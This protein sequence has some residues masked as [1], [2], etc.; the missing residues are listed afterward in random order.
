MVEGPRKQPDIPHYILD[1]SIVAK[2][3]LDDERHVDQ[4][5]AL[6]RDVG[7]GRARV[8]APDHMRYEAANALRNAHRAGRITREDADAAV[9]DL[10]VS[11]FPFVSATETLVGAFALCLRLNTSLYD[12][13][14]LSLADLVGGFLVSDDQ[15]LRRALGNRPAAVMWL[16]DYEAQS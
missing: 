14:Y 12:A 7:L 3:Y 16:E 4:A 15:R 1:A 13:L 9:L 6:R 5:R 2:W 10:L 8:S 11:P